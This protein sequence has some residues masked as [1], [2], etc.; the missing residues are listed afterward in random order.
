MPGLPATTSVP[1]IAGPRM[2]IDVAAKPLERVRLLQPRRADGLRHEPDLGRDDE[3]AADAV[4]RLQHD[5][6]QRSRRCRV[7]TSAAVAA[8]ATPCTSEA[9]TMHEVA[10]QPVGEHAAERRARAPR[11]P[12]APRTRCRDRWRE[13]MSST[14]NASAMPARRSPTVVIVGA[15]EEQPVV[16][17]RSAPRFSRSLATAVSLRRAHGRR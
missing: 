11:R 6:Q 17:L 4:E 14:A 9:P 1:P 2:P 13:P 3:P 10:R 16:A 15:A 12:G 7:S 8:C 5:D